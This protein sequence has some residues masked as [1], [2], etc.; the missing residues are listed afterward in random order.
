ASGVAGTTARTARPGGAAQPSSTCSAITVPPSISATSGT[1]TRPVSSSTGSEW[2]ISSIAWAYSASSTSSGLAPTCDASAPDE[3]PPTS[4]GGGAVLDGGADPA[5]DGALGAVPPG[6]EAALASDSLTVGI[7]RELGAGSGAGGA[8]GA[9]AAAGGAAPGASAPARVPSTRTSTPSVS[10]S[11]RW[12]TSACEPLRNAVA[13]PGEENTRLKVVPVS[14]PTWAFWLTR[15]HVARRI[16]AMVSRTSGQRR[17]SSSVSTWAVPPDDG[18]SAPAGA[19]GLTGGAGADDGAGAADR[20]GAA[21]GAAL[22]G[23]AAGVAP[24]SASGEATAVEG[25][26]PAAARSGDAAGLTGAAGLAG[27]AAGCSGSAGATGGRRRTASS[28]GATG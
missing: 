4:H 6:G 5:G 16:P 10:T 28:S 17:R 12:T 15:A 9:G 22:A 21:D 19:A 14:S 13:R 26:E 27:A 25:A 8:P 1:P 11:A 3:A 24:G 7:G 23:A 2:S 18:A 20:A